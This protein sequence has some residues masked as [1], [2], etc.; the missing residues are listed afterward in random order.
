MH[1]QA[2]LSQNNRHLWLGARQVLNL[3]FLLGVAAIGAL[4]ACAST[5]VL[6]DLTYS[7]EG[8][9]AIG[10][11]ALN[12]IVFGLIAM[13]IAALTRSRVAAVAIPLVWLMV[14]EQ[15]LTLAAAASKVALPFWL[16][17]PN[18][19]IRQLG[20]ASADFMSAGNPTP[21]VGWEAGMTQPTWFNIL[22]IIAWI[23]V[24]V[25]AA[26]WIN[27]KRDVK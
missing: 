19:R 7:N 22:V 3:V 13:A 24:S 26:I 27:S 16:A 9:A 8:F 17:A 25:V 6:P 15:L 14:I 21:P 10:S 20:G 1:A 12:I 18:A 2:Y 11:F 23:V 4:L 5:L